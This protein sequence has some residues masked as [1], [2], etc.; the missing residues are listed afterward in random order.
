MMLIAYT[1]LPNYY[2]LWLLTLVVL[3]LCASGHVLSGIDEVACSCPCPSPPAP[4]GWDKDLTQH[5]TAASS[6]HTYP[7]RIHLGFI[8]LIISTSDSLCVII[9]C[10]RYAKVVEQLY[11]PLVSPSS[12]APRPRRV[13]I[14]T[15]TQLHKHNQHYRHCWQPRGYLA[16]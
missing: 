13:G 8:Y 7:P 14:K 15:S 16:V 5:N 4:E 3:I 11:L 2:A 1:L 6:H 12:L 10:T 9:T